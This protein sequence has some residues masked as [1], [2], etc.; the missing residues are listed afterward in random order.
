M[1]RESAYLE[2]REC[3]LRGTDAEVFLASGK[4][5]FRTKSKNKH[6]PWEPH[7]MHFVLGV[8]RG[9]NR[10]IEFHHLDAVLHNHWLVSAFDMNGKSPDSLSGSYLYVIQDR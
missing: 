1:V 9:I 4:D 10:L 2:L 6:R 7:Q 5:R 3:P 8:I